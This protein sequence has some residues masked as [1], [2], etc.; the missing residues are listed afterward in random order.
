MSEEYVIEERLLRFAAPALYQ[1]MVETFSKYNIHPYDIHGTM[2]KNETGYELKLR[3]SNDF[4]QSV[5][6]QISVEQAKN[7]D[8]K[9]THFFEETADKCKNQLIS[10]Y[11]KMVKP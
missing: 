8:E 2:L 3:F 11:F 1:R 5:S 6:T 7:P 9:I 10:D 4:S